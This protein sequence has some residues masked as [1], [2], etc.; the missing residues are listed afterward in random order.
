M[1][2]FFFHLCCIFK[3]YCTCKNHARLICYHSF[4]T[5]FQFFFVCCLPDLSVLLF[6]MIRFPFSPLIVKYLHTVLRSLLRPT[7][8]AFLCH[9]VSDS[10]PPFRLVFLFLFPH[11]PPISRCFLF[12]CQLCLCPFTP[13]VLQGFFRI[14][15]VQ[16]TALC[17]WSCGEG[18]LRK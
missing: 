14:S 12:C 2:L 8:S 15:G 5:S 17:T 7:W 10:P 1:G 9:F 16:I 4:I 11:L 13:P 6:S 3:Y 18:Q